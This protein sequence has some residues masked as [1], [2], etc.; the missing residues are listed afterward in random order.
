MNQPIWTNSFLNSSA[1]G[2]FQNPKPLKVFRYLEKQYVDAFFYDG[3]L[4]ISSVD[5]FC[6]HEDAERQDSMEGRL[7]LLIRDYLGQKALHEGR[8]NPAYI[9]SCSRIC[10]D[11]LQ[12]TFKR[13]ARMVITNPD[14]FAAEISKA[15][16]SDSHFFHAPCVYTNN[17]NQFHIELD[18]ELVYLPNDLKE[19]R[20][21]K[22]RELAERAGP[23]IFF[24]KHRRFAHQDE[25]RFV[26]MADSNPRPYLDIKVPEARQFC[27][28]W[29]DSTAL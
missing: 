24:I 23:T 9:L 20:A 26:W 29:E 6:S 12:A 11:E 17:L 5:T 7:T 16:Q 18:K 27:A 22:I 1:R 8:A 19:V 21:I 15:I 10:S 25:Y 4:R 2:C 28:R 14:G 3:S 13:N